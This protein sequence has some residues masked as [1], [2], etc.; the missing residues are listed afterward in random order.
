[1]RKT[2]IR[3]NSFAADDRS[4]T[5]D[6]SM[7]N[8]RIASTCAIG[9][10][11]RRS[12]RRERREIPARDLSVALIYRLGKSRSLIIGNYGNSTR[13][14]DEGARRRDS[15]PIPFRPRA[16]SPRAVHLS[17]RRAADISVPADSPCP[18][19]IRRMIV[20]PRCG[21]RHESRGRRIG[22]ALSRA[23]LN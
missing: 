9:R 22:S 19:L 13:R 2:R 21:S 7:S 3:V 6:L 8:R 12:E 20:F 16:S 11:I 10:T 14:G 5:F 15:R 1:M 17:P 23:G 18:A 4:P